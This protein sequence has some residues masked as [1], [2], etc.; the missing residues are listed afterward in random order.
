MKKTIA[1]RISAAALSAVMTC[2]LLSAVSPVRTPAASAYVSMKTK[3]KTLKVGQKYKMTLVNNTKG[4][5]ISKIGTMDK[6]IANVYGKKKSSFQIKG[7]SEG[8]TVVKAK[9]IHGK[10]TKMVKC[11]VKVV[12]PVPQEPAA[13]PVPGENQQS[14]E[15][16]V[17][18][19]TVS[20]Q[21]ELEAALANSSL[22][23]LTLSSTEAGTFTIPAGTYENVELTVDTPNAGIKNNGVFK[24]IE[25]RA[26]KEE[27]WSENASGNT[28]RV[29]MDAGNISV[30]KDASVAEIL[31]TKENAV[32]HL[33]ADG[34]VQSIV[35][36]A[37]MTLTL[38]G[39]PQAAVPVKIS[40]TAA[41]AAVTTSVHTDLSAYADAQVNLEK[42]A[43]E[44]VVSVLGTKSSVRVQNH[45]E[46]WIRAKRGDG[47]SVT[48]NKGSTVFVTPAAPQAPVYNQGWSG[49]TGSSSGSSTGSSS[50]AWKGEVTVTSADE[51][52]KELE[53]AQSRPN[54]LKT[55]T[56]DIKGSQ[57][58]EI[59][60]GDYKNV[61]LILNSPDC[62]IV[63]ENN[64]VRI[65]VQAIGKWTEKA[66]GNKYVISSSKA[67]I[68]VV[69]GAEITSFDIMHTDEFMELAVS[70][71]GTVQDIRTDKKVA[72]ADFRLDADIKYLSICELMEGATVN[73]NVN[74]TVETTDIGY[75]N[76]ES[77]AEN[78]TVN[79]NIH[80]SVGEIRTVA[81]MQVFNISGDTKIP[82][83]CVLMYSGLK[84]MT[85]S[86][87]ADEIREEREI[88]QAKLT[89]DA[90]CKNLILKKGSVV[91]NNTQNPV[92]VQVQDNGDVHNEIAV[93]DQEIKTGLLALPENIIKG[94]NQMNPQAEVSSGGAISA[95][96]SVVSVTCNVSAIKSKL[97]ENIKKEEQWKDIQDI[98]IAYTVV[99]K[100]NKEI[101]RMIPEDGILTAELETLTT[102]FDFQIILQIGA[103]QEYGYSGLVLTDSFSAQMDNLDTGTEAAIT[104]T[105]GSTRK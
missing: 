14:P 30:S 92:K 5:K 23:S 82:L 40:E 83:K 20:T 7:K 28:L 26:V 98:D 99:N 12:A 11:T 86:V 15:P 55:I 72:S 52:R 78:T 66:T 21:E 64:Y 54:L 37:K 65:D 105:T 1:A 60:K 8:R 42:G 36:S 45:S 16:A 39:T 50:T 57:D 46:K 4:W 19:M 22:R 25:I 81:N 97:I 49:S 91:V 31:F 90:E 38:S 74:G 61:Q 73:I 79:L 85:C 88:I 32:I 62:K 44:S 53:D 75:Q 13:E 18:Q 27:I 48:I 9:L 93:P 63:N 58:I 68:E 6:S 71:K 102:N 47:T 76:H 103:S 35:I 69:E 24:S 10:T 87:P 70:G 67:E 77:A 101:W 96:P 34:T 59:P 104:W 51:L 17:T 89:G 84:E 94:T 2:T 95:E 41:G 29:T 3:F 56:V 43:E 33:A 100:T 80:G